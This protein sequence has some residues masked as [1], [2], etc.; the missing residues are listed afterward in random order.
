MSFL[1]LLAF[2]VADF[3]VASEPI[4]MGAFTFPPVMISTPFKLLLF[5]LVDGGHVVC[6]SPVASFA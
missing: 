6:E 5:V 1:L 4:S 3:F 2:L